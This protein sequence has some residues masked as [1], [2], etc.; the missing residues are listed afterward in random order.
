MVGHVA[1]PHPS[2]QTVKTPANNDQKKDQTQK[3]FA[4]VSCNRL[5]SLQKLLKLFSTALEPYVNYLCRSFGSE[6]ALQS[7]T[8]AKH[9][10]A[11]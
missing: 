5:V 9:S 8:K 3:S 1:T 11:Q 6:N 4:C 10:A 2:K 7:H